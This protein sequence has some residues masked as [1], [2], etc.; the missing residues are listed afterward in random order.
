MAAHPARCALAKSLTVA[1]LAAFG[2]V[3]ALPPPPP[4]GAI[5]AVFPPWW[6]AARAFQAAAGA[7]PVLRLGPARFVALVHPDGKR[8]RTRLR[9]AGAWLLLDPRGLAGCGAAARSGSDT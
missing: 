9:R 5:L 7:G 2:L 6:N 3:A 8:A 1:G 4:S